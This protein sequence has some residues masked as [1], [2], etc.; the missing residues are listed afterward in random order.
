M[1][2]LSMKVLI[3]KKS[4]KL[5]KAPRI[6]IYPMNIPKR[7]LRYELVFT[8]PWKESQI[9]ALLVSYQGLKSQAIGGGLQEFFMSNSSFD[10][11]ER[12]KEKLR[13]DTFKA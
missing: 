5:L 13:Q 11:S 7:K 8:T 10:Q 9:H 6:C 12:L 1:C 4:R 3:R 2:V